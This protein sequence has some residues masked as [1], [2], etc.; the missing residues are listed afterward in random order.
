MALIIPDSFDKLFLRNNGSGAS[1][2][3]SSTA[4]VKTVT[5]NGNA[6]QLSIPFTDLPLIRST[7]VIKNNL[8]AGFFNGTS[9]YLLIPAHADFAPGTG[10]FTIELKLM[11]LG[12]PGVLYA[13]TD[14]RSSSANTTG[15]N[16]YIDS[17]RQL[18]MNIG[19][20]TAITG[21]T[22]LVINTWYHVMLIGNGAANGSRNV[23]MYLDAVQ[24][25]STW[26]ADYNFTDNPVTPIGVINITGLYHFNG[27]MKELRWSNVART[28]AVPTTQY[29]SDANTKLLLHFNNPA[30][31]P[32]GP[33]IYFDGAG[34][35]LTVPNGGSYDVGTGDFCID[36]TLR[37]LAGQADV[38]MGIFDSGVDANKGIYIHWAPAASKYIGI[39]LNGVSVSGDVTITHT[40]GTASS[41]RAQRASGTIRLFEN[42]KQIYSAANSTN[43]TENSAVSASLGMRISGGSSPFTGHMREVRF[44]NVVRDSNAVYTPSQIGFTVD[45]N[46]KLYIKGNENN[47]VTTF[48]DSETTPKTV[49]TFGDT[50][51]KYTED[52]RSCIFKDDGNTGHKPYPVSTCKVDFF[53]AFGSGVAYFDGTGDYLS[54]PDSVDWDAANFAYEVFFRP[55]ILSVSQ[56]FVGRSG[57]T[58]AGWINVHW[59]NSTTNLELSIN[60]VTTTLSFPLV[61]GMWHYLLI[62]RNGSTIRFFFNGTLQSTTYAYGTA[63]APA[64]TIVFGRKDTVDF[65][66]L[67]DN[68]RF[69]SGTA[70]YTATFNPPEDVTDEAL[71]GFFLFL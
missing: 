39:Y 62:S 30:K 3:D 66:G 36:F 63:L 27:W 60:G 58:D 20:S 7:G 17:S 37:S 56:G 24:D 40:L 29:T 47:G 45:A 55:R 46:T 67:M 64:G 1:F 52:Y 53:S 48:I 31:S 26:T 65:D 2:A 51:I 14:T 41:Y 21:A 12:T 33:A 44:S 54:V 57:A 68:I 8:T 23:K 43:I 28:V 13:I 42:G 69:A 18:A 38:A 11:I 10:A 25:G 59:N 49:T 70:R 6:T 71:T 50:K 9:D 4:N 35:Y 34:D 15:F 22:A 5:A 61:A 19:N 32:I 16:L